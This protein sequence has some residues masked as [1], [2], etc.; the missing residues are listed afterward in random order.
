MCIIFNSSLTEM[1]EESKKN[2][3]KAQEWVVRFD[4]KIARS[5]KYLILEK[6]KES[7]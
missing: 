7:G 1:S 3:V 6:N 2:K 5:E 4:G